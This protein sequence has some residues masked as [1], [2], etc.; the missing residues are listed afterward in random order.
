M[1][2]N[3]HLDRT[4][5]QLKALGIRLAMDDFGTGYS[6]LSYLRTY[7]FDAIKIDR[8][9]VCDMEQSRKDLELVNA[10]IAM[11]HGLGMTVI[12]EG[13]ERAGQARYLRTQRCDFGQ[14]FFW[15][16]PVSA[17]EFSVLLEQGR[18]SA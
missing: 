6:S 3:E 10:A 16:A 15:S 8:S 4:L 9:F 18:Q 13:V 7:P 1:E 2:E 14:G 17:W 5:A 11:G 12:A